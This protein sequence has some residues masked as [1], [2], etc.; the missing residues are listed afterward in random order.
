MYYAFGAGAL[1][2]VSVNVRHDIVAN[3]FFSFFRYVVIY[4][5]C[6]CLQLCYLLICYGKTQ[7]LFRFGQGYPQPSPC[8]ELLFR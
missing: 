6:R 3:F 4:V 1:Q 5:I 8:P 7:L 2:S